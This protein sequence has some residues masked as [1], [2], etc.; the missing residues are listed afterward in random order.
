MTLL[1]RAIARSWLAPLAAL[2]VRAARV[3]RH[4]TRVLA[5]SARWLVTSRE[6]HNYTYD[7]TSINLDH[8]AWYV[9]AVCDTSVAAIAATWLNRRRSGCGS[10]HRDDCDLPGGASPTRVRF[11]TGRLVRDR[12]G[13][14][15][16]SSRRRRQ[17]LGTAV[18][19]AAL[20]RPLTRSLRPGHRY[21][22]QSRR[23]SGTAGPVRLRRRP[24]H[25][26]SLVAIVPRP[27]DVF[28]HDSDHSSAHERREFTAAEHR[29][30][31]GALLLSDNVTSTNVLSAYAEK[32]GRRF[33]AFVE[34]PARHWYPGDG[35]GAAWHPRM[36]NLG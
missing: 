7:L 13:D 32:T 25:R 10:H 12:A 30:A 34:R 33:L 8:L 28:L 14:R 1:R 29:L 20:L 24:G 11:A 9:A 15:L 3:A 35:I 16:M 6:H 26:D 36:S 23:V 17:G 21:R 18:L 22:H 5:T 27:P 2:P 4:D 19:A 31:P